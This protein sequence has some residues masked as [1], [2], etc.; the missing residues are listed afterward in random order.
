MLP[1]L[2]HFSMLVSS[3]LEAAP[4]D[5]F[6]GCHV[7]LVS[8]HSNQLWLCLHVPS[9]VPAKRR[10]MFQTPSDMLMMQKCS[11]IHHDERQHALCNIGSHD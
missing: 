7:L 4:A 9:S 6:V 5:S 11:N 1:L 10:P 8:G 3:M 2:Q